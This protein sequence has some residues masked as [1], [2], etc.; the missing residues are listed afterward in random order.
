M[1]MN[2]QD[3]QNVD[4]YNAVT[5]RAQVSAQAQYQQTM[6]ATGSADAATRAAELAWKKTMDT[7]A[8]TG[9]W[10]GQ[11]SM[12]SQTF[13]ANTFGTWMPEGPQAGQ[14]T[15]AYQQQQFGQGQDMST[16]FGRYYAPGTAP[17]QGAQTLAGQQQDIS[18]AQ[19]Y[20]ELYG[21]AFAPGQGPTAGMQTQAA[22]QQAFSQ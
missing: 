12:P 6:A 14:Q 22:Q 18:N 16:L 4:M 1:S 2:Y 20:A 21:T 15:A 17:E 8:M 13:F 11:W 3:Y 10:N 7:A 19:R 9:M 5:Q